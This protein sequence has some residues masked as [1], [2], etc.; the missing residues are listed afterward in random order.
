[1]VSL[2]GKLD[3]LDALRDWRDQAVA[4]EMQG[5]LVLTPVRRDPAPR[6]ARGGGRAAA[7]GEDCRP[8]SIRHGRGDRQ[9]DVGAPL[10]IVY[11]SE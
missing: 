5:G 9:L 4:I 3:S 6:P 8:G 1:V 7:R 10:Q 11:S 2:L